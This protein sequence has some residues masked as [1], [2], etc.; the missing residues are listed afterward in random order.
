MRNL[1]Y[2]LISLIIFLSVLSETASAQSETP[3]TAPENTPAPTAEQSAT[4]TP[5]Q[6]TVTSGPTAT[7]LPKSTP[8]PKASPT[9]T[10]TNTPT[11]TLTPTPVPTFIQKAGGPLGLILIVIGFVLLGVTFYL[12]RKNKLKTSPLK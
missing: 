8:T 12:Y 2:T 10:I 3:T 6:P 5:S 4:S 7:I 9:E 11:P 1:V